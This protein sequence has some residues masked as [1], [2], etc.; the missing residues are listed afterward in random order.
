VTTSARIA[1]VC[2]LLAALLPLVANRYTLFVGNMM[3][4]QIILAVGLNLL[5]GYAGLLAFM[6]GA[7]FGV[8]AYAAAVLHDGQHW[9][10]WLALPAAGLVAMVIGVAV[11]LPAL[12]LSGLYLALAT[13]AFAQFALWAFT[14]WDPVT[15][16]PSGLKVTPVDFHPLPVS[17]EFGQYWLSL[18]V[19]AAIVWVTGN[20]LRSRIGRA[21]V[22]I[23]ESET[24]AEAMAIDVIRT[25]TLAYALA[26]LY[27]GIAGGLFAP[28]LGLVVPESFDLFQVVFQ[29]AMVVVGGMGSLAGSVL[30]A[31]L[32]V[33]L[34]EGLRAFKDLQE[35]AFGG[36][37][38]LTVLFLPGGV[39][40]LL[41]TRLRWREP[42]H[43]PTPHRPFARAPAATPERQPHAS[44]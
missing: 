12:R 10:Y 6:N 8:G 2:V 21:F 19:V 29:F 34:H 42:L 33:W 17:A 25:K 38:L 28:M 15:G 32:M 39:A 1:I 3:L 30:G 7:L 16:G 36:L 9:P 26:A 14:H 24:A 4:V 22:A 11:A 31:A 40:G 37:I 23:R 27:A 5:V 44:T 43:R 18:M 35:I 13:V 20:L 41:R